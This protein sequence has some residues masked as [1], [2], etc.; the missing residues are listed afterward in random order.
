VLKAWSIALAWSTCVLHGHYTTLQA[1][2]LSHQDYCSV[3]WSGAT[4]RDLG[5]YKLAQNRAARLA[6]GCKQR[7]KMNNKH[8]SLYWLK[9]KERSTSSLLV[10]V[11]GT[12]MHTPQD[13]PPEVSSQSPSP[14]Q[15]MGGAQHY[16]EP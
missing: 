6:L 15:T 2:V 1:L 9:V 5:K 8:V 14:E 10:F 4:K 11:R 16:I 13:M 12:P 7:A 3:L